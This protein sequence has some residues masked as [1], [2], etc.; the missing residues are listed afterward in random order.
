MRRDRDQPETVTAPLLTLDDAIEALR[1]E[2][3]SATKRGHVCEVRVRVELSADGRVTAWEV[4]PAKRRPVP[5]PRG[6]QKGP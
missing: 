1:E 4:D 3:G 5:L 6:P 2:V